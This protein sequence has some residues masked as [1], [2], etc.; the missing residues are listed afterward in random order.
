MNDIIRP[1]INYEVQF[2]QFRDCIFN[3]EAVLKFNAVNM[4]NRLILNACSYIMNTIC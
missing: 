4:K 2:A 1:R 3:G